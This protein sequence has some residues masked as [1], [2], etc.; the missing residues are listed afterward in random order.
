M[1]IHTN[2]GFFYSL[3]NIVKNPG[4]TAREFIEGNR[5]NHY[6]PLLM[7]FVLSGIS[8]FISFKIIKINTIME[9]YYAAHTDQKVAVPWLNDVMSAMSSYNSAIMLS[10][11]PIFSII[12]VLA[13]RKWGQNYYE[14][15]IM[16]TYI[17]ILFT[18][19]SIVLLS[20][21]MYLLKDSPDA[22][23]FVTMASTFIIYPII[24]LWFYKQFYPQRSIGDVIVKVLLFMAIGII[25]YLVLIFV[26]AVYMIIN[27]PEM[28]QQM[29]PPK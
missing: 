2:K 11:I 19:I 29:Q 12:T 27:H 5:V 24:M 9:K 18:V 8:A 7:V 3:K 10:L 13:F 25:L 28:F 6:K 23:M 15:I 1:V 22:F 17:Q 20:P 16:N 21:L 26:V 14:H 4:K